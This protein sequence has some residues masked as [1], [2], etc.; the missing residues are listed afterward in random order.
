MNENIYIIG[1]VHGC[2]NT[3]KALLNKLPTNAKIVFV[4]DLIDR[5]D[6]SAEVV[7]FIRDNNFDCVL[8]NHEYSMIENGELLLEEPD[9]IKTNVW[10]SSKYKIGGLDTLKSYESL[11]NSTERFKDDIEWMKSLPLYLEYL[12]FKTKDNRYLVVSHS[13][14]DDTWNLKDSDDEFDKEDFKT[15]VLY[16]RNKKPLENKNLFNVFGHTPTKDAIIEKYYANIDT[17][18]YYKEKYG[19][20]TALEFP[21][22]NLIT[23]KNIELY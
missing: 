23:Q 8:G 22:M 16:S 19:V 7:K 17:G 20:L 21:A 3:L 4:G 6:N 10:T 11:D 15:K 1:D 13:C 18:A 14:V 5:G 9:A 12:D 2:L